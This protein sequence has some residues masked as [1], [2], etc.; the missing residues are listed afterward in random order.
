MILTLSKRPNIGH[1]MVVVGY[2]A[3]GLVATGPGIPDL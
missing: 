2:G 3:E 1:Y